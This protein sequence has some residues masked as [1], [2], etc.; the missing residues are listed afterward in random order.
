[1]ITHYLERLYVSERA[2]RHLLTDIGI[3][4]IHLN[5]MYI[6]Y[7]RHPK[8]QTFSNVC[9]LSVFN[10]RGI[11]PTTAMRHL[12]TLIEKQLIEPKQVG[13]FTLYALTLNGINLLKQAE[14]RLQNS[15]LQTVRKREQRHNW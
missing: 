7:L 11:N 9:R 12:N 13:R 5:L 4:Q 15:Q 8:P 2:L 14:Y 3:R 1:M 10:Y 6:V